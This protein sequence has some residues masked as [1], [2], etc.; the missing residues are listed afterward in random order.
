MSHYILLEKIKVE[1][2]NA[3]AGITYGFPAITQFLGF[4][5]ALSRKLKDEGLAFDGC[6][7]ICHDYRVDTYPR[8]RDHYFVQ[9]KTSP[10]ALLN[11]RSKAH[12][13]PPIIEEGKMDMTVSILI[14][15]T[16]S[17][18][19]EAQQK[20]YRQKMREQLFQSRLAGGSIFAC[21][22]IHFYSTDSDINRIKRR[23]LPGFVLMDATDVLKNHVDLSNEKE[24]KEM[25]DCWTDFFSY[26]AKANPETNEVTAIL[27]S[28]GKQTKKNPKVE[29]QQLPKPAVGWFVPL[30]VGY[31][32]ISSLY[33]AQ[34]VENL[35]DQRY[36][37][38]FVESVHSI[39]EWKGAHKINNLEEIIW[40]YDVQDEWY[41]CTQD[42]KQ[43]ET[44]S[45]NEALT[46]LV[47]DF[48]SSL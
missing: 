30:M 16:S 23:L 17:F 20:V 9:K 3:I 35:R 10:S 11:N 2:A 13:T 24:K 27:E 22:G 18:G 8:Y 5:H 6:A 21:K 33:D 47:D 48:F 43:N 1:N 32:G 19:H 37:F 25:F 36:P 12:E 34:Q 14:R 29:W 31:K 4:T 7:I 45:N 40:R 46:Q 39:G 38:R 42:K 15:S 26:R 44:I 28:K 41:L